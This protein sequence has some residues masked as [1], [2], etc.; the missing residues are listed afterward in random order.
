MALTRQWS[1]VVAQHNYGGTMP[2]TGS[3]FAIAG[4][5]PTA[6]PPH[7]LA[8]HIWPRLSVQVANAIPPATVA[9]WYETQITFWAW[10]EQLSPPA[11]PNIYGGPTPQV[12]LTGSLTPQVNPDPTNAGEYSV[13]WQGPKEGFRSKGQRAPSIPEPHVS[14]CLAFEP[15]DLSGTLTTGFYSLDIKGQAMISALWGAQL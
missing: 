5:P 4:G 8:C 13:L 1:H 15:L 2:S 7:L 6:N 12:V 9:W 10:Y 11:V 14:L 3:L